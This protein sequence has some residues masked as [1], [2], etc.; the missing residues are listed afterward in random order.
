MKDA[1]VNLLLAQ[2][3]LDAHTIIS[4]GWKIVSYSN[5][6]KDDPDMEANISL[7]FLEENYRREGKEDST[8]FRFIEKSR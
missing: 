8:E 6:H 2:N 3:R 4:K 7:S 5:K 1:I